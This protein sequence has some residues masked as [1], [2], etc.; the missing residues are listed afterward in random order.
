MSNYTQLYDQATKILH[1]Y[2][3]GNMIQ[4]IEVNF[5]HDLVRKHSDT[6]KACDT[7]EKGKL[8]ANQMLLSTMGF[9]MR[10][11]AFI[12]SE[13]DLKALYNILVSWRDSILV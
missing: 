1:K 3:L 10:I 13:E 4:G 2:S 5:I 11:D 7:F 6:L 12:K 8:M 9:P